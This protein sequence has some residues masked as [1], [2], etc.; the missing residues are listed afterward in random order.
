MNQFLK[1]IEHWGEAVFIFLA[2]A[3]LPVWF[4]L[5]AIWVIVDPFYRVSVWKSQRLVASLKPSSRLLPRNL[6]SP[7]EQLTMQSE[8]Q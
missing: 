6:R 7:E 3:T 8:E 1:V 2:V 5:L 4:P